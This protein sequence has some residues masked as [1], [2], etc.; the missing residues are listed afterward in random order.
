MF[1]MFKT[2]VIGFVVLLSLGIVSSSVIVASKVFYHP[3]R[4]LSSTTPLSPKEQP[5][6]KSSLEIPSAV[7]QRWDLR[8]PASSMLRFQA[9]LPSAG[10][11]LT[12]RWHKVASQ[13]PWHPSTTTVKWN[14]NTS[15]LKA[16]DSRSSSS[17][18]ATSRILMVLWQFHLTMRLR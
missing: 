4:I 16:I 18:F 9:V 2:I 14:S 3:Q 1:L 15:R 5:R 8:G 11:S 7:L 17:N 6:I 10:Q 13:S 12:L